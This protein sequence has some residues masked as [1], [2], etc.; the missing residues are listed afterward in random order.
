MPRSGA[1]ALVTVNRR[2]I[3]RGRTMFIV[4][5]RLPSLAGHDQML[6]MEKG[7]AV[8]IGSHA[9]LAE[10]DAVGCTLCNQQNRQQ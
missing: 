4:C 7:K 5:H 3:A 8:D 9:A 10:R 2:R 6:A 1:E